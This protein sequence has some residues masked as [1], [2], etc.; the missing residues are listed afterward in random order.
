MILFCGLCLIFFNFIAK[1]I[2][3]VVHKFDSK[4]HHI[5]GK[6]LEEVICLVCKLTVVINIGKGAADLVPIHQSLTGKQM[7]VA[8][9]IVIVNVQ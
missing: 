7:L 3:Y 5:L 8:C 4:G 9:I 2:A 1:M 6:A